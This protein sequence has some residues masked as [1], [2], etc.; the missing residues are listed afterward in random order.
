M[1]L[2]TFSWLLVPATADVVEIDGKLAGYLPLCAAARNLSVKFS[3]ASS[4]T[5]TQNGRKEY[6][7]PQRSFAIIQLVERCG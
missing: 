4:L 6:K 5:W 1:Q 2:S 7:S 3:G